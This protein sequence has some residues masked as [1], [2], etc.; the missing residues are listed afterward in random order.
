[1]GAVDGIRGLALRPTFWYPNAVNIQNTDQQYHESALNLFKHRDSAF[2]VQQPGVKWGWRYKPTNG[3]MFQAKSAMQHGPP[4]FY[5][6]GAANRPRL[7]KTEP[8]KKKKAQAQTAEM[9]RTYRPARIGRRKRSASMPRT[10]TP[11]TQ[12]S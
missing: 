8:A 1:M 4:I 6:P 12:V 10:E 5:D 7:F 2:A 11:K 9:S 3:L